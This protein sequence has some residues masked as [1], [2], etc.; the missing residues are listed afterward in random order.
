MP[1]LMS[2]VL[3]EFEAE[4]KALGDKP[5]I[6]TLHL[7][8]FDELGMFV[9][10]AQAEI[11]GYPILD[12]ETSNYTQNFKVTLTLTDQPRTVHFVANCPVDQIVYGHEASIIG[13]LHVKNG[14]G[15]Y[16]SRAELE[17]IRV[18][19]DPV[20]GE[21]GSI[22]YDPCDDIK[23]SLQ[24][25]HM[26]RNYA[27]IEIVDGTRSDDAFE[28]V[29]YSIYNTIDIGTVAPYNSKHQD[30]PFQ[31]FV[32]WE[33]TD[34]AD[35]GLP[36]TYERLYELGYEGHALSAAVLNQQLPKDENGE[37]VW[38][39][40][41]DENGNKT[42]NFFMYE[43]KVSVKTDEEEKWRESP[44]HVIVWGKWNDEDTY[45]KFDLVYN[46]MDPNDPNRVSEIK[47]YNILRNFL[48]YFTIKNVS[49]PGYSSPEEAIAGTTSNNLAGSTTTSKFPEVSLG[50][51]S[52]AVSYTA[53]TLVDGGDINFKYKYENDKVVSNGD[54][55][56]V[57]EEGVDI[58][59][60]PGSV[61]AKATMGQ[62]IN[63]GSSWDG[64]R[65]V[66]LT[67]NDP[68]KTVEEQIVELKTGDALL[69][70]KVRFILRQR[71]NM[72]VECDPRISYGVDVPQTVTI[73]LPP[74]LTEDLF[75][76]DLDMEVRALTLSPDADVDNNKLPVHSG[77]STI[78]G[79][80]Q[81]SFYF[82]KTILTYNDYMNSLE[83]DAN[84]YRI[85]KTYWRTNAVNN[86]SR[87]Y[88]S[89]RYF[90]QNSAAWTNVNY[91]FSNVA[92]TTQNISKGLDRDVT[93]TF[94]MDANDAS[95]TSREVTVRLDGL[96]NPTSDE[97]DDESV[98]VIRPNAT[99]G[100]VAISGNGNA[101]TVTISGLK[102]TSLEDKVGFTLD[103][104]DY[105]VGKD[106][107]GDRLD[108]AFN[109]SFSKTSVEAIAGQTVNYTFS[110]PTLF[111]DMVVNVTL[112][113][114][115][116][117]NVETKLVETVSQGSI[118]KYTFTPTA[119]GTY[120]LQLQTANKEPS[121]CYITLETNPEFYYASVT[122]EL[123]QAMREFASVTIPAVKQGAGRP[124][125]ISFVMASDDG[126]YASKDIRVSLV[127]MKRN[128]TE[129]SFIVNTG[130]DAV[131]MNGRTVTLKNIYTS[132]S[133]GSL[134]VTVAADDYIAKTATLTTR[135]LAQFSN[136][137]LS[138]TTLG[139]SAGEEVTL[140]FNI[141]GDNYYDG[142]TVNIEMDG[143]APVANSVLSPV[144]RATAEY[145][146]NPTRSGTQTIKLVTTESTT[147]SKTCSIHLKAEGFEDSGIINVVQSNTQTTTID[148]KTIAGSLSGVSSGWNDN[149]NSA[150]D[151]TMT[152][153][154][155]HTNSVT[156]KCD[157]TRNGPW[158]YNWTFKTKNIDKWTVTYGDTSQII[159]ISLVYSNATYVGTCTVQQLMN[160]DVAGVVL[161]K[162]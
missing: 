131:E 9:E 84:N 143:L 79:K 136:I 117:Q 96:R 101:R 83:K 134:S 1:I 56:L 114:L 62:D 14:Q 161:T 99:S 135:A 52:L 129:S 29:G 89:N 23:N 125:D 127:G 139:A 61:I 115:V 80:D 154:T 26:L 12:N 45:Y 132:T 77:P 8:V 152:L 137:S 118:K 97:N 160:G 112:D 147:T 54:V 119:T 3:P 75:P 105:Q 71:F 47:Y 113:G 87:I 49:G 13:N 64:Y 59:T 21:D 148:K 157:V 37:Y 44:P 159:N 2:A 38:Y 82:R 39:P 76:L 158:N 140:K 116:P 42:V 34:D 28:L 133:T 5:T 58:N 107:S 68:G 30:H 43:R 106:T 92:V 32:N 95:S 121:I 90:N 145:K 142:M 41:P 108:N 88:V 17:H 86:A 110:I 103:N 15:A 94:T 141:D 16:W 46:I 138:P 124:V 24:K 93:I 122:D 7:V 67:I 57:N 102:T 111:K 120:T 156:V 31:C 35:Y 51:S 55:T 151:C 65:N 4:T 128:G 27:Q 6:E 85:V 104:A 91:A 10:L 48:Y 33:E 22:H 149:P 20:V 123:N 150:K 73:K 109:G 126:N 72:I 81:N 78:E 153:S 144:T 53:I 70:R 130:D 74:G 155:D 69:T 19:H 25:V 146:Y 50:Q 98:M 40:Q 63:D 100:N 36:Y 162:Q 60:A 18:L 11:L 66:T